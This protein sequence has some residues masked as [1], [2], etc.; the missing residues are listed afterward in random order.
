MCVNQPNPEK[1]FESGLQIPCWC[2]ETHPLRREST[3]SCS[4]AL[5]IVSDDRT[6]PLANRGKTFSDVPRGQRDVSVTVEQSSQGGHQSQ[7]S[8][9]SS[10]LPESIT[11]HP[12][13]KSDESRQ[14]VSKSILIPI[15]REHI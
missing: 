3:V 9:C 4:P 13:R 1:T 5:Y 7:L 14:A 10:I 15:R 8:Y 2:L 12:F 11:M 6:M